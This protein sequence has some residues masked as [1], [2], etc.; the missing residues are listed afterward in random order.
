MPEAVILIGI[1]GAGKSTFYR[2]RFANTHVHISLDVLKTR[3]RERTVLQECIAA[4]RSFAVDNTNTLAS[5]RA[6]YIQ[7]AKQAG[8]RV[9]GYFFEIALGEAQRRNARREGRAKIPPAGVG[10][11]LKRLERPQLTEGFDDLITL[12]QRHRIFLLSPAFAG[13]KRAQ[14]LLRPGADFELAARLRREGIPLGEAFAFMSGLYFRGKLAYAGAFASPPPDI[15]GS[16]VI[17]GGSGL[18]P[19]ETIV[20]IEQL[21]Y[22]ATIPI[23]AADARY[24]EPLERACRTLDELAGPS[25]DYV[26]L[27][28]VATLKY[29]EPMVGVFDSR[30]LFPEEFAGRGDMSRGGL[31]LRCASAGVQLTYVPLGKLTRHGP[32]PP[33]LPPMR[34]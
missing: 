30:L 16:F 6:V 4:G 1:P 8:Y 3:A 32:R 26:L 13:G 27:G 2:E 14:I 28:S 10:G 33:K 9:T 21:E 25:T 11:M 15:P 24:R 18:V 31:M 23:D 34:R 12:P 20:T 29:L 7:A 5:E 19:P 22:I 17:T